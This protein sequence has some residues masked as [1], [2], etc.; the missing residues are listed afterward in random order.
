MY[1]YVCACVTLIYLIEPQIPGL[2]DKSRKDYL[3]KR[4]GDKLDE[5]EDDIKD[6]EYMFEE[7][8]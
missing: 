4:R 5:L 7:F 1:L 2:R 3:K 8:E 6:E